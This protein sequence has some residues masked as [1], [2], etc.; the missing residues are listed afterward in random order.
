[1][2]IK[3]FSKTKKKPKDFQ[4]LRQVRPRIKN[5][6]QTSKQRLV[7]GTKTTYS[8]PGSPAVSPVLLYRIIH[9][10]TIGLG[11]PTYSITCRQ[12][13]LNYSK[14][15]R[16]IRKTYLINEGRSL[17][18]LFRSASPSK[19]SRLLLFTCQETIF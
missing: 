12:M 5:H 7:R 8:S 19:S 16:R 15:N 14:G 9:L 17:L 6:T 1:M 4:M 3:I 18:V 13:T 11:L 2:G 10:I